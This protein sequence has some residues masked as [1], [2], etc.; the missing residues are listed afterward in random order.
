MGASALQD[1]RSREAVLAWALERGWEVGWRNGPT[2][3]EGGG[4]TGP[5]VGLA[6][7]VVG[8][9]GWAAWAAAAGGSRGVVKALGAASRRD[10]E[11]QLPS[12][13]AVA[14]APILDD[15][16][17]AR[18]QPSGQPGAVGKAL[19]AIDDTRFGAALK[20]RA[21]RSGRASGSTPRLRCG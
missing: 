9:A 1:H 19:G 5:G 18:L 10:R 13:W 2:G 7:T 14:D 8:V 6:A 3:D 4:G 17:R 11:V 16:V 12:W 15:A 21:D 20:R